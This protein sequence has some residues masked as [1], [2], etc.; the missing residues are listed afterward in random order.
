M[1]DS[2]IASALTRLVSAMLLI[3]SP[4]PSWD[5]MTGDIWSL[6]EPAVGIMCACLP[7]IRVVFMAIIPASW[8][9]TFSLRSRSSK[10][11]TSAHR[12]GDWPRTATYNEIHIKSQTGTSKKDYSDAGSEDALELGDVQGFAQ[13][14]LGDRIVVKQKYEVKE[15]SVRATESV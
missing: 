9:S 11:A 15:E 1:Y 14:E 6:I 8:R 10:T 12:T 2:E 7:T 3:G 5:Y 13:H 4:D